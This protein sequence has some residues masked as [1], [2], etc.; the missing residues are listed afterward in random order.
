M[1]KRSILAIAL[2]GII[3]VAWMIY[4]SIQ[5]QKNPPKPKVDTTAVQ[6]AAQEQAQQE[7]Q[8]QAKQ[9]AAAAALPADTLNAA[10]RDSLESVNK[11]GTFLAPYTKGSERI[12][13]IEND[14]FIAKI[15]NKGDA[16][17]EWELKNFKSWNGY[18]TQL[19]WDP[20]G[21]M[22]MKFETRDRNKIDSRD[23]YFSFENL[24]NDYLK[25]SG[26]DSLVVTARLGKDPNSCI[27][28]RY[29]FYGDSYNFQT[30]ISLVNVESFMSKNYHLVWSEGL[31][32]QERNSVDESSESKSM[33]EV[34]GSMEDLDASSDE[35]K[36]NTLSGIIDYMALKNKY[37]IA[38][39]EPMP[40]KKFDGTV[41]LSG[42][43][44]KV[45]N[46]G[47]QKKYT[48]SLRVPYNGGSSTQ[49]FNVYVGPI[50]YDLLKTQNLEGT[51]NLGWRLIIRPIGEYFMLPFFKMIHSFVPNFG[52]S[53]LLFAMFIKM[54]LY[55]LSITQMRGAQ[56]MQL[57]GPLMTDIREKYKD[58]QKKQQAEIMKLYSEY[59]INPAG[60]C[61][62]LVLQMPILYALWAVLSKSIDLRQAHFWLWI[63]DL[64]VPD[65]ILTLPMRIPIINI[66]QFS[67]LALL[68]GITMFLQQKMTIT[69]PRQKTLVY[70]MP[71]MF[72]LM[73]S[74]F[75][76]G[77]N[78][79]YFMFN[80]MSILQQTYINKFSK[81][82][83]TL[84]DLKRMP[85]KEGW[86]Q[87]KMKEAQEIAASQGRSIPGAPNESS[88]SKN[89]RKK[90]KK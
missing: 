19:I 32:Y 83:M 6:K 11:F 10:V 75:P 15:S 80:L 61:L 77:L 58:D 47:Q 74:N 17:L 46:N 44:E 51:V 16:I 69:D 84:A 79:Y 60:G 5:T 73:F 65:V 21:E 87:K 3:F 35:P 86:F 13:T 18:Q 14:L 36:S 82:K 62:P 50:N 54:L 34:N 7:E 67:G 1:D 49:H 56:R 31:R 4:S 30:D 8:Q 48:M 57:I 38:A 2:I 9:K 45:A 26:K 70:I 12:I 71:V 64:S 63:T 53:I 33:V 43:R 41:D 20:F 39:V 89:M 25:V 66:N 29:V 85:K 55:P 59:G 68:M 28:Q 88:K 37:F 22:Y 76:S 78:L 81:K 40:Y 23:L 42:Y 52:I 72:T 27:V 90:P 24:N